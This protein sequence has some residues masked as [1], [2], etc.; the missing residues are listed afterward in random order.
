M[1]KTK[2]FLT[3]GMQKINDFDEWLLYNI[4]PKQ[5]VVDKVLECFKNK[6]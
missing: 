2:N 4:P 6:I 5:K 1:Q 3:K